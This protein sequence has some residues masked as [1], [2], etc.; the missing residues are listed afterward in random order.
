MGH[1]RLPFIFLVLLLTQLALSWAAPTP[2]YTLTLLGLPITIDTGN[3]NGHANGGRPVTPIRTPAQTETTTLASSTSTTTRQQASPTS[4]ATTTPTT[5]VVLHTTVSPSSHTTAPTSSH[6]AVSTSSQTEGAS[7]VTSLTKEASATTPP[8][9]ADLSTDTSTAGPLLVSSTPT[10]DGIASTSSAGVVPIPPSSH[11]QAGIV[12]GVV[13]PA[14][15]L[16][17]VLAAGIAYKRRRDRAKQ[18]MILR[19]VTPMRETDNGDGAWTRFDTEKP[20]GFVAPP[21][22]T[23]PPPTLDL[24][25]AASLQTPHPTLPSHSSSQAHVGS[26]DTDQQAPT[27][28]GHSEAE[29]AP[30]GA[31]TDDGHTLLGHVHASIF[32][33]ASFAS[34]WTLHWEAEPALAESRPTSMSSVSPS[35]SGSATTATDARS[36]KRREAGLSEYAPRS[37][38]YL[39]YDDGRYSQPPPAYDARTPTVAPHLE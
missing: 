15:A 6:T 36:E 9:L 21:P 31:P 11:N 14:V 19:P 3:D 2:D 32:G 18:L 5:D 10:S 26:N 7:S 13:I 25:S 35:L 1:A 12:L 39:A 8:I 22:L 20:W 30:G 24:T 33:P 4:H 37:S 23:F 29:C 27:D 16:L 28:D 17:L 38:H 34:E